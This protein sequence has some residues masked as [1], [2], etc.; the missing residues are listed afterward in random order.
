MLP[1][2]RTLPALGVST[3]VTSFNKVDLPAPFSPTMPSDSPGLTLK[4]M[5]SSTL[6]TRR[7][8]LPRSTSHKA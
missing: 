3:P 6:A 2:V 7:G 5:S 1:R 8:G 4:L